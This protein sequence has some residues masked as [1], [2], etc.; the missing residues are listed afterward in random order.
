V[1]IAQM[2]NFLDSWI[3]DLEEFREIVNQKFLDY[4]QED[5]TQ[6]VRGTSLFPGQML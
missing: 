4:S 6:S 5:E 3:I 1:R 2:H